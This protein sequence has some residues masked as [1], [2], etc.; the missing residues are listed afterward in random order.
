MVLQ[1]FDQFSTTCL[2]QHV[3]SFTSTQMLKKHGVHYYMQ[4]FIHSGLSGHCV[5][6]I[7]LLFLVLPFVLALYRKLAL[8][9]SSC[10]IVYNSTFHDECMMNN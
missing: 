3:M 7:I 10:T 2:W 5:Q 8:L 9:Y 6:Y 1:E 4:L